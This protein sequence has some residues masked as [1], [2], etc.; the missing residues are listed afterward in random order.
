MTARKGVRFSRSLREIGDFKEYCIVR[1]ETETRHP[2][3]YRSNLSSDEQFFQTLLTR[4]VMYWTLQKF[5][6]ACVTII[7]TIT[8]TTK[9]RRLKKFT[10]YYGSTVHA[11]LLGDPVHQHRRVYQCGFEAHSVIDAVHALSYDTTQ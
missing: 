11:K 5:L 4:P 2:P 6:I 1:Q 3:M 10:N 7:T 8:A 9:F